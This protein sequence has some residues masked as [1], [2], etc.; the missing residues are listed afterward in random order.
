MASINKAILIGRLGQDPKIITTSTGSKFAT[1]TMA[2]SEKWKDKLTG[3]VKERTE[4]HNI[5]LNT[6]QM[7]DFAERYLHKGSQVF[8]EGSL[9]NREWTDSAGNKKVTTEIAVGAFDGKIVSLE[10]KKDSSFTPANDDDDL[11]F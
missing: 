6:P 11:S 4:W 1:F 7:A 5:V 3:E 2:T 10:A 9:K 8:V